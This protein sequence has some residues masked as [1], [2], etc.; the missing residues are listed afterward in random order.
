MDRARRQQES[1]IAKCYPMSVWE[2]LAKLLKE[3][4]NSKIIVLKDADNKFNEPAIG[5]MAAFGA[6]K[7]SNVVVCP[8]CKY[9]EICAS[10]GLM[11]MPIIQCNRLYDADIFKTAPNGAQWLASIQYWQDSDSSD[12]QMFGASVM[13]TSHYAIISQ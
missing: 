1:K 7:M 10:A 9:L 11:A 2:E 12:L 3:T 8:I 4:N 6:A 13:I 5:V